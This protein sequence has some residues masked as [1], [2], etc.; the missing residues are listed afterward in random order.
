[1]RLD[2]TDVALRDIVEIRSR[3][4]ADNPR[5]GV[6]VTAR[7]AQSARNLLHDVAYRGRPGR[8]P[9][10]RELPVTGTPCL[11]I[12]RERRDRIEVLRV[13]H[14]ARRWPGLTRPASAG[15]A[16][17]PSTN[18][19]RACSRGTPHRPGLPIILQKDGRASRLSRP[20][21]ASPPL[22]AEEMIRRDGWGCRR[23]AP[24]PPP[25][26]YPSTRSGF[27]TMVDFT[28]FIAIASATARLMPSSENSNSVCISSHG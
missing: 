13:L 12:Y 27:G 10:T 16:R 6:T 21:Q 25:G 11:V 26:A 1:M 23:P 17:L 4:A 19:G 7:I 3:I 22:G 28:V 9:G 24:R 20:P 15:P 8:V 5:A 14:G 2:W 18:H